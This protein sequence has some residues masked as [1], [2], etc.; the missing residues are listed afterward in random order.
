MIT[1]KKIK[2]AINDQNTTAAAVAEKFNLSPQAF[3]SFLQKNFTQQD[4]IK[5]ANALGLRYVSAFIDD[6]GETVIG[7]VCNISELEEKTN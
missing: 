3:N 1:R 7:G 5:I 6:N 2:N 4:L